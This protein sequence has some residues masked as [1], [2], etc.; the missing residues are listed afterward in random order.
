[1]Q[2]ALYFTIQQVPDF[3]HV[4]LKV[5]YLQQK[6][7]KIEQLMIGITSRDKESVTRLE[8]VVLLDAEPNGFSCSSNYCS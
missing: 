1:M 3:V 2:C 7:E 8:R 4:N 5:G 6:H